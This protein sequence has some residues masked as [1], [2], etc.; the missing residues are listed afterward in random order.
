MDIFD[1]LCRNGRSQLL[2]SH[3]HAA[4]LSA[5]GLSTNGSPNHGRSGQ[6]M[7]GPRVP[8]DRTGRSC[9][10][11]A[12]RSRISSQQVEIDSIDASQPTLL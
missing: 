11:C 7:A 2:G 4:V 8:E 1:A 9:H 10:S 12:T 6:D 3:G 5:Q